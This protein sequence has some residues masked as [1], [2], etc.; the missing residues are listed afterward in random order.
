MVVCGRSDAGEMVVA[1]TAGSVGGEVSHGGDDIQVLLVDD[2][3]L[4]RAG[5]KRILAEEPDLV[6]VGEMPAGDE[7][8]AFAQREGPDI[9]LVDV[10]MRSV[11]AEQYLLRLLAASPASKVIV[12]TMSEDPALVRRLLVAGVRAYI[13]KSATRDELLASLRAMARGA[14]RTIVSVSRETVS[15]LDWQP[16]PVRSPDGPALS[17]REL[18][19]LTLLARGIRNAEIARML[20]I[21]EGTVKRHLTNLYSKLGATSRVD[22]VRKAVSRNLVSLADPQAA[23]RGRGQPRGRSAGEQR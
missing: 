14:E 8:I 1:V 20:D 10:E 22:A 16:V 15:Q 18:E 12:L 11:H 2:N 13:L 9:V 21:A 19:V 3:E 4:F 23:A 7:A 6:V 5:I 17:P